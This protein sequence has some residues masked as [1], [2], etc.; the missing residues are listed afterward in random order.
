MNIEISAD[1]AKRLE[2]AIASG[3]F[4][5]VDDAVSLGLTLLLTESEDEELV[6]D[7]PARIATL[8][9]M[10]AEDLRLGRLVDAGAVLADMD[11]KIAD[12]QARRKARA[13]G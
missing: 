8:L 5:S 2:E 11:A 3:R 7:V 9:D 13:A 10:S 1:M 4:A 6:D 12:Y